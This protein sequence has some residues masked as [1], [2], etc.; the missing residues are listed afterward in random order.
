MGDILKEDPKVLR[1]IGEFY[2]AKNHFE[3]AAEIFGSLLNQE[4]SGE[5]YQ[6]IA[7]CHQKSGNFENALEG[8]LKAELYDINRLWNLKKIALCYRNLKQPAKA[9][10]YYQ[11]AEKIDPDNM[12]NQL[13]IGHCQLELNE[14]DE[15][16]KC[17]FK[18]EYLAPGNKK[19]WRPIAWCS[20][21]TGKK[22]QAEKYL[23]QLIEDEPNKH[24]F[25]N[26]GHVQWSLGNHR[27]ALEYYQKSISQDGF[28]ENEFLEVFEEDLPHLLTQG[29]EN[30]DVPIMLDQLRYFLVKK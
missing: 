2:F 4:K 12:N 29:I 10:E 19:V 22:E 16:L 23:K 28:S 17:Y 6:K 26:M 27:Y 1:N 5:L 24:D 11:A 30:D 18:V 25:M 13:N 20:F 7:Y 8:Y 3:D 21:L 9:L 14:F 15:A